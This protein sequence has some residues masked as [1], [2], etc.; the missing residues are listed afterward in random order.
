MSIPDELFKRPLD[1]VAWV[2]CFVLVDDLDL[3]RPTLALLPSTH[4][5]RRTSDDQ[6]FEV[7]V[8]EPCVQ[9]LQDIGIP[10]LVASEAGLQ[11]DVS[12]P[13]QGEI[14]V[15]GVWSATRKAQYQFLQNAVEATLSRAHG[16]GLDQYYRD[17]TSNHG[18]L[19]PI[20]W[21]FLVRDIWVCARDRTLIAEADSL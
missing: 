2:R 20:S 4:I 13:S 3:F 9:G 15:Q 8:S 17:H 6:Y 10:F 18:L 21:A 7:A 19:A 1:R 14:N 5:V 12:Q 11:Y 16:K